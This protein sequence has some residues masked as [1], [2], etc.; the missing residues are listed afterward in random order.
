MNITG[1]FPALTRAQWLGFWRDKANWFWL[2]FFPLMFLF[3][4]GFLFR[5]VGAS[6]SQ[7]A[8]VGDIQFMKQMPA[9]AKKQF[10][11]LFKT[12]HF[13]SKSAALSKVRSGDI[14]GAL[15]EDGTTLHLYYSA[16]DQ[17]TASTVQGTLQG[18]VSGANQAISQQPVT[19][20]LHTEQVED[21][22]LKP[23]Q[24]TAPGLLGWAVAMGGVFNT[25]M[26]LVLWRTSGLLRRLRLSPV[27]TVSLVGSRTVV[28]LVV[29]LL[30]TAVFLSLAV[31]VFDLKL[32]GWWWLCI[33]LVIVATLAFMSIG[34]L[35]GAISKTV[36]AASGLA[37]VIIL[38]MAFLSGS[39]IPR[40]TAPG[41]MQGLA[42]VL[43]LGQFNEG[44]LDVMV[45]GEG[46]GAL[47][48]PVLVLLGFGLVF[49]L[50]SAKLFR[51][52]D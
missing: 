45:R 30:Q 19:F 12:T 41:W 11:D 1:D 23:I 9:P 14:D 42:K 13:K 17:V 28:C 49:G 43:P 34:M 20:N 27:R 33:P 38:P 32:T 37:N 4:F 31:L 16:A 52:E 26:P 44:L 10:D 6:K 51:W 24:Y 40:N 8:L 48:E 18:F 46:P 2:L 15:V 5:D 47:V 25:A 36:E 22:S 7:I 50:I 39:F 3:L 21:K 29:A 35:T